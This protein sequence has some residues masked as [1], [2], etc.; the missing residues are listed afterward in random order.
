MPDFK[1]SAG[2]KMKGSTFYGHGNQSPAKAVDQAVIDSQR[3]LGQQE[4][5]W[6]S[7]RW[8]GLAKTILSPPKMGG[9]GGKK[10]KTKGGG[11]EPKVEKVT[12]ATPAPTDNNKDKGDD[13]NQK[14]DAPIVE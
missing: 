9:G 1:D 8:A 14:L 10:N 2:Y 4:N 7:P 6:K 5:A 3:K 12:D 13:V 11:G